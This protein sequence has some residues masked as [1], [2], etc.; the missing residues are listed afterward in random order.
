[1]GWLRCTNNIIMKQ[2]LFILF[3][4]LGYTSFGQVYQ[5]YPQSMKTPRVRVDS[6]L[7]LP[8]GIERTR[9][10]SGG[11]DTGQIRYNKADSSVYIYTGSQW[12]QITG[13]G[14]G[15]TVVAYGKNAGGDSTILLLSNG[16]R[17]AAKDS[18]GTGSSSPDTVIVK[19]PCYIIPAGTAGSTHDSLVCPIDSLI[20]A[21]GSGT[22]KYSTNEWGIL[23]DSAT[24]DLYKIRGDSSVLASK[25]YV[26]N[27]L[28]LISTSDQT[29][30]STSAQ[31]AFTFTGVPASYA[32]YLIFVN[33]MEV[34]NT[35]YFTTSG[36]IVTFTTGLITGDRVRFKRIK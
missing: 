29:L 22:T 26:D 28:A 6:V 20:A 23:I 11:Q 2:I 17:Y 31:T 19:A 15:V 21:A 8:L 4:F 1:M 12:A 5:N 36:N 25:P 32:D 16:T 18:I 24:T 30:V 34:E 10:I 3:I 14:S 33:G 13:G 35:E 27:K 9:N 7:S